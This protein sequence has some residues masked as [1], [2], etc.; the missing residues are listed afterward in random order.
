MP[1]SSR[2][3]VRMVPSF[4]LMRWPAAIERSFR[5]F[6]LATSA[7]CHSGGFQDGSFSLPR[8]VRTPRGV[9]NRHERPPYE[10]VEFIAVAAG[11]DA[12]R[13][14]AI[15][16]VQL[17]LEQIDDDAIARRA[18]GDVARRPP[19]EAVAT[20]LERTRRPARCAA[21]PHP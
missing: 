10:S 7:K 1:T 4:S 11:G 8:T 15:E 3:D 16:H 14:V 6:S 20:R 19:L 13:V 5:P 2:F 9:S 18:R 17:V 12:E 21:A